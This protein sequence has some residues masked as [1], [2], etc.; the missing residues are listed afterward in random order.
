M[1]YSTHANQL[2]RFT[3]PTTTE[4]YL[5]A[6]DIILFLWVVF[7]TWEQ[8]N[9]FHLITRLQIAFYKLKAHVLRSDTDIKL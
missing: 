7:L 6:L 3:M 2:G 1:L 8:Y 5:I 9:T 4:S